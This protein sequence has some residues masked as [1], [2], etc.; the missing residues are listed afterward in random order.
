MGRREARRL[1]KLKGESLKKSKGIEPSLSPFIVGDTRVIPV[2]A[3]NA[4]APVAGGSADMTAEEFMKITH[5]LSDKELNRIIYQNAK[6]AVE[7]GVMP[8]WPEDDFGVVMWFA[9]DFITDEM[10]EAFPAIA[11][12]YLAHFRDEDRN[13]ENMGWVRPGAGNAGRTG[14]IGRTDGAG[15]KSGSPAGAG[16][17]GRGGKT[18]PGSAAGK[19]AGAV[20]PKEFMDVPYPRM[21]EHTWDDAYYFRILLMMLISARHGSAYSRNFLIS[22]YKVYY[23]AEYNKVKRLKVLTYLDMLELHDE[24]CY[25]HGL[26][27]GHTMNGTRSFSVNFQKF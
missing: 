14:R 16:N 23:K 26:A 27:S 21:N 2:I 8:P 5:D 20:V 6:D 3:D 11:K 22:L 1:K 4:K 9:W 24:D 17:A 19:A 10:R 15:Q 18:S 7:Q 12:E 13:P 25:R